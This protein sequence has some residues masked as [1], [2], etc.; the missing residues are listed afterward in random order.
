[1]SHEP[2]GSRESVAQSFGTLTPAS[3]AE[4]MT[5]VSAGTV[6]LSP[7]ISSVTS[8]WTCLFLMPLFAR[9]CGQAEVFGEVSSADLTGNG[10]MP[11]IAQS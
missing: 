3:M 6:T 9:A 7:S 4:R 2:H 1:M 11:P 10:V 8:M 5:D